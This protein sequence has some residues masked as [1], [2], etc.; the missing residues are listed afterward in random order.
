M[1]RI[2]YDDLEMT[3]I[4]GGGE[5]TYSY[6]GIPF[7]GI[8]IEDDV[9]GPFEQEYENGYLEGWFRSYYKNGNKKE[10]YKSHNNILVAGTYK[11]WD[12]QGNLTGSM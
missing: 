3:G 4:D 11:S 8:M 9:D 7:T 12:E 5:P 6:N 2:K 10:E 1:E